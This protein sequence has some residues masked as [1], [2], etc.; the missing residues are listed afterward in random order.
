[1]GLAD[2]AAAGPDAAIT[3]S[4]RCEDDEVWS[5]TVRR[6]GRLLPLF[7]TTTGDWPSSCTTSNGSSSFASFSSW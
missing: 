5:A 7:L 6:D 1:M 4:M 2:E 3:M